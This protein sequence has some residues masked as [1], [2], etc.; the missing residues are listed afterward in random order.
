MLPRDSTDTQIQNPGQYTGWC[1]SVNA[2]RDIFHRRAP[3]AAKLPVA[4]IVV[5]KFR[6][7]FA[8]W[9]SMLCHIFTPW[10]HKNAN[11]R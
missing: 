1:S 4:E 10:L 7:Q 9:C 3:A 2:V 5:R 11:I 8:V 6:L